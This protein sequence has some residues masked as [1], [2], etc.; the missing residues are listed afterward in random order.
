MCFSAKIKGNMSSALVK[1][2]LALIDA[3]FKL[4]SGMYTIKSFSIPFIFF[5]TEK[6]KLPKQKHAKD[7]IPENQRLYKQTKDKN[8]QSLLQSNRKLTILEARKTLKTKEQIIKKNK[9]KLAKIKKICKLN[10]DK[11][12]TKQIIARA[13]TRKPLKNLETKK[14]SQKTVFTDEDFKKFEEEYMDDDN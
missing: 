9:E 3:D 12:L 11:K 8:K 10:L 14:K 1:Q 7:L 4:S 6:Q 2:S 13:V 5:S